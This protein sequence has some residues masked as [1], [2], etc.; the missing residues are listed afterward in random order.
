VSALLR[1]FLWASAAAFAVAGAEQICIPAWLAQRT[2]WGQSRGWQREIGFW[3]LGMLVAVVLVIGAESPRAA[4]RIAA[5]LVLMF[6]CFGT[7]HL[8][9]VL[10]HPQAW[11]HWVPLAANY[12]GVILGAVALG[13]ELARKAGERAK[14]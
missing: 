1:L 5:A 3:N 6:A 12:A 7:N 9:A 2:S 4:R 13:R 8:V 11:L 10:A 14:D